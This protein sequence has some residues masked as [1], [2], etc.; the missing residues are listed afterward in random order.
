M[1]AVIWC[2]SK[3][4]KKPSLQS[5]PIE[6]SALLRSK[7]E[8]WDWHAASDSCGK[9][10]NAVW[11]AHMILLLGMPTRSPWVMGTLWVHGVV[12]PS[13]MASAPRVNNGSI[14]VGG[15]VCGN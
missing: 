6:S 8:I 1:K 13:K 2:C 3:T 4:T 14:V 11:E 10:S 9:G 12:G 5:C 15:D 7:G